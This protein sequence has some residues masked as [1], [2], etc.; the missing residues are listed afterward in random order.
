[1][2]IK[3]LLCRLFGHD[4]KPTTHHEEWMRNWY[5]S[6]GVEDAEPGRK[7]ISRLSGSIWMTKE[8]IAEKLGWKQVGIGGMKF[9]KEHEGE[10]FC[11]ADLPD[12]ENSLDAIFRDIVPCL[13]INQVDYILDSMR[14][15][16]SHITKKTK[17]LPTQA[18]WNA[19]CEVLSDTH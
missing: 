14:K 5:N 17:Y 19:I 15:N 3:K 1:M 11:H 2:R 13:T 6:G 4:E 9:W 12:W 18:C 7:I 16:V 8:Q 10:S